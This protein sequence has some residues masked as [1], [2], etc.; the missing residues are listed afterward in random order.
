MPS[1]QVIALLTDFGNQD[2]FVG[3][4][5]GVIANIAPEAKFI[6]ITHNI[7]PGDIYRAAVMLWQSIPHFP[8]GSVFLTVVDP[9]VGSARRGLIARSGDNIFVGP[10]NGVFT[11]ALK[12]DITAWELSNPQFQLP[13]KGKTFHGR[14]VFAPA[15]AYAANGIDGS[16]FG[17]PLENLIELAS[18]KLILA[19]NQLNGEVL[20]SD[21]FGNLL[22]SIGRFSQS[23]DRTFNFVPW[24]DH[25]K[26]DFNE[27]ALS[28]DRSHLSLP[29]GKTLVW[30]DTFADL[31]DNDC[32]FLVGS[33]GLIEIVANRNNAGKLLKLN[34]GAQ[35]TLNF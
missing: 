1:D 16:R 21:Q 17:A 7:P 4:M 13:D 15:A 12:G 34:S 29:E 10:D 20:Y 22:T 2:P 14:D 9:G 6:D 32:G 25:E 35:I 33:S 18:P 8:P 28:M 19:E 30:V 26:F 31:P 24:I 11:F 27:L 3:I 23:G 5:K